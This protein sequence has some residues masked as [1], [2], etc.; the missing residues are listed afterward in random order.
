ME[1]LGENGVAFAIAFTKVDKLKPEELA[2]NLDIYK[3][4][5]FKTWEEIPSIF[6]TSSEKRIGRE[7]LMEF[8][9]AIINK[10]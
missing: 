2:K 10:P 7:E 1:W 6:I 3:A 5:L 8:I 4:E 9:D